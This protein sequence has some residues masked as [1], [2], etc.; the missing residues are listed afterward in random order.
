MKKTALYD[1]H[2]ALGA[3]IIP[4]AGYEMPV[5]YGSEI[6]EHHA[7]RKSVGMFDV[8]HMGE[9]LVKGAHALDLIQ[10]I[11]TNDAA[12]LSTGKV[13]YSCMPN[14]QGGIVDDLLVYQLKDEEYMLVVNASNIQKDWDWIV[15]N[16]HD[17]A[18]LENISDRVSLLAIQG[19]NAE[20]TL[21]KLTDVDLSA[22]SYYTFTKGNISN[23]TDGAILSATGYTGSGGFEVYVY[24]E[25]AADLWDAIMAAGE[26]FDIKPAGLGARDTL[27][28]EM[29]FALYGNDIDDTTSPIE[30]GLGWITKFNK[31]F[32]NADELKQQKE[33]GT[34]RKLVAFEMVEKGIPRGGYEIWSSDGQ[35]IGKVTSGTMSPSLGIGIGM[36]YVQSPYAGKETE[37]LIAVRK[38]RLKA[39][40]VKLP[41]YKS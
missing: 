36:G 20:K 9:F 34:T 15:S 35:Q 14:A 8:S 26:E 38:R 2:V 27:R 32:V 29:G 22:L 5:R 17:G 39:K 4:F 1:K 25:Y 28:L 6:E 30:A 21:Q 11:C 40:V 3:K 37:L 12:K 23:I 24:N 16:N 7:V 41:F 13:Q 33:S 31:D 19:P 18:E 10:N